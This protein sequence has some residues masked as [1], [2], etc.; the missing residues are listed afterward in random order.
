M[1]NDDVHPRGAGTVL[2]AMNPGPPSLDISSGTPNVA[3][4][5]RRWWTRAEPT[6]T[7][8]THRNP[9]K[10]TETPPPQQ[11]G[12]Q[13][14]SPNPSPLTDLTYWKSARLPK[15]LVS[16]IVIQFF[17][18]FW[19]LSCSGGGGGGGGATDS[20]SFLFSKLGSDTQL[21]WTLSQLR[22]KSCLGWE[23][24]KNKSKEPAYP[25]SRNLLILCPYLLV[26]V[27]SVGR[28]S[29]IELRGLGQKLR[30]PSCWVTR[31]L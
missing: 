23:D 12:G 6:E 14:F 10:P 13:N 18:F 21:C 8:E 28:R 4:R 15:S 5:E 24:F 17:F 26:P 16:E 22:V 3:K 11:D 1:I 7:T 9:P 19:H 29:D 2:P 25:T 27:I 20:K 30:P 31:C